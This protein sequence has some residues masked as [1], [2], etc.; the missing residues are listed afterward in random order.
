MKVATI[1]G[2]R[3]N[4]VKMVPISWELRKSFTEVIVHKDEHYDYEMDR[5]F[6]E[7]PGIPAPAG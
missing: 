3:P 5:I 1:V 2:D 6:F 7:E 4:F